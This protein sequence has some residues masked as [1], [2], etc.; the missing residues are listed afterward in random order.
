MASVIKFQIRAD[1]LA[2][3]KFRDDV[4]EDFQV[5]QTR[6]ASESWVEKEVGVY[7]CRAP[8]VRVVVDRK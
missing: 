2:V 6:E 5:F 1:G 3:T 7:A 4:P 8:V